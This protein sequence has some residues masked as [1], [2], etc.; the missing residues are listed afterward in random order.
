MKRLAKQ[1]RNARAAGAVWPGSGTDTQSAGDTISDVFGPRPFAPHIPTVGYD[2]DFH[3]GIDVDLDIGDAVRTPIGGV[4]NRA[5]YTHFGFQAASQ[6][7]QWT[8][9]DGG[10]FID[11][12]VN[13][14]L[15]YLDV[16]VDYNTLLVD[17]SWP[18]NTVRLELRRAPVNAGG[19]WVLELQFHTAPSAQTNPFG[20]AI[21]DPFALEHVGIYYDGTT[22][23][24]LGIDSGGAM[25]GD[26][27]T[28]VAANQTWLRIENASGTVSWLYGTDGTTW[29]TL[30]TDATAAF[31]DS[32]R[33][34]FVPWMFYYYNFASSA[35]EQYQVAQCNSVDD[36][37]IGR[38]GNWVQVTDGARR[39]AVMHQ[40]ELVVDAGDIVVPGQQIGTIGKTG[41]D[42]KSGRIIS[43]HAHVELMQDN[44]YFYSNA[45]PINPLTETFFPRVNVNSN[46]AVVITEENDPNS[47]ASWKMRITV[48]RADEDFDLNSVFFESVTGSGEL[49]IFNSVTINF[50][51]RAGLNAD[52]DIPDEG[53]VYIVPANFTAASASYVVDLFFDKA[54]FPGA[55][56]QWEVFDTEGTSLASG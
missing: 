8:E 45:D 4:V 37:T 1:G 56:S 27:A 51:T 12:S 53:G 33:S 17:G 36:D 48:T 34:V 20:I 52:P 25:A 41:F 7:G 31:T 47:D 15:E 54:Q 55:V 35:T 2:Y 21:R 16:D 28:A 5:H 40:R 38:F 46:V 26:G 13:E 39:V 49:Q 14:T 3:R 42:V 29:T 10:D 50:D 44:D 6:L 24:G 32:T 22:V 19:D 23:T 9:V 18:L 11:F 43:A 30:A